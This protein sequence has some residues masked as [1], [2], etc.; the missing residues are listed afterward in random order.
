MVARAYEIE[1]ALSVRNEIGEAPLW[2]PEEQR[3]YWTDTEASLVW[4]YQPRS[5]ARES[6][7]LSLPVTSIMRR[8]NGGFLLVTKT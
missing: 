7:T 2:V 5:G 1:Q 3:L 8:E 6:W 4:S